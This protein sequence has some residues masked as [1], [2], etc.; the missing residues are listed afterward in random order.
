MYRGKTYIC[1]E[2]IKRAFDSLASNLK[3]WLGVIPAL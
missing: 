2:N 3:A 1:I